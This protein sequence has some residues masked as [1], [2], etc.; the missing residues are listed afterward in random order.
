[1]TGRGTTDADGFVELFDDSLIARGQVDDDL[2]LIGW[3]CT[4]CARLSFGARR[5]CPFCGARS[6]R[7]TRLQDYGWLETW[8][9]VSAKEHCYT[10][11]YC[12]VGDG[13]DHQEVRVFGPL[14]VDDEAQLRSRQRIRVGFDQSEIA[15]RNSVHHVFR[16]SADAGA[17]R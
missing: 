4:R 17:S 7:T 15:G 14:A 3:R 12:M 1:M 13:E 2:S 16:S 8:T 10:V 5:M 9:T 11:G 6:G